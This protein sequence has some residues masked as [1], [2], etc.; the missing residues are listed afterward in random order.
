[1]YL[2][3]TNI[4]SEFRK[5][6]TSKENANVKAW[7][8]SVQP[9]QLFICTI[10]LMEIKMGILN[11]E[12]RGDFPQAE[13]LKRWYQQEIKAKFAQRLLLISG[14][15]AE[16]CAELHIPNRRPFSDSYIAATALAHNFTLVTRNAKDFQGL[17]LKLVN[18]FERE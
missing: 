13:R 5:I 17:K 7:L 1:M 9:E 16:L 12:H 4:L 2:L 11:L 6:G 8:Q 18:P 14:E 3:D 10:T 15:I